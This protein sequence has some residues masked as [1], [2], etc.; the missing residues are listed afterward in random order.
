MINCIRM[1]KLPILIGLMLLL[2]ACGSSPTSAACYSIA[3]LER[4]PEAHFLPT[5]TVRLSYEASNDENHQESPYRGVIESVM[6][7][8]QDTKAFFQTYSDYLQQQGW[9]QDIARPDEIMWSKDG[10]TL[11]IMIV[12]PNHRRDIPAASKQAHRTW[13]VL[14]LGEFKGSVCPTNAIPK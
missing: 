3:D 6:G 10:L 8:N 4:M 9:T 11:R 14:S 5:D 7:S 2:A 13:Y 12:D 1:P